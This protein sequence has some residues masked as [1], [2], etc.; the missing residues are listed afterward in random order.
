MAINKSISFP[1]KLFEKINAEKPELAK[2]STYVASLIEQGF[3]L[4]E[5]QQ[6]II[7]GAK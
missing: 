1:V 3:K 2:L 5:M 4:K 7:D 6:K